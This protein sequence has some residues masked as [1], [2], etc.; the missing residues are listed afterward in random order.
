MLCRAALQGDF[1]GREMLCELA[2]GEG[3]HLG[4]REGET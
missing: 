1:C 2:R 3:V 4:S